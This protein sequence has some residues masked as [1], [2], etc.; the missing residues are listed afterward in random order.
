[1]N[2]LKITLNI[3]LLIIILLLMASSASGK[4]DE[5]I[6]ASAL[7]QGIDPDLAVAIAIVE[8]QVDPRAIGAA[9]ERG[10]FQL[11]PRYHAIV[12]DESENIDTAI[13]YLKKIEGR[14]RALYEEAW[15]V[16]YN[17][18]PNKRLKQPKQTKYFKKVQRAYKNV[19]G[20]SYVKAD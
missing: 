12:A 14:C 7:E 5:V 16:C 15:Y 2:R 13:A 19:K 9:G 20:D 10:V 8:S 6:R 17:Y 1:M 4:I 18:G 3:L 11:H